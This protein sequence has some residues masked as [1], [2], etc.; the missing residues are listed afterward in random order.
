QEYVAALPFYA[1]LTHSPTPVE[2]FA[3]PHESHTK[4]Q[5]RHRYA[6]YRRYLDWFRYW[7]QD[8]RDPDPAVEGQYRRWDALLARRDGSGEAP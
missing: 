3:Y 6:V 2:L 4:L 1:R 5:P 8:Y 7:L